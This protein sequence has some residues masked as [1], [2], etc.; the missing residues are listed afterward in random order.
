MSKDHDGG[1]AFP[2]AETEFCPCYK[3]LTKRDYFAA[4]ALPACIAA[5][6]TVKLANFHATAAEAAYQ[7]ADAMLAERNRK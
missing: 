7:I 2:V 1:Q 6:L 5:C 4:A 3:G